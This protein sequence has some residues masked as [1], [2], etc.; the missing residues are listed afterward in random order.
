MNQAEFII[1]RALCE[2]PGTTTQRIIAEETGFSL[3]KVNKT[4]G[5]LQ[6]KS[7][8]SV[9]Y[10]VT[11]AGFQ[12]MEPY[13]VK[14]A[15]ILA[16]G[17][18]TRFAPISYEIPKGLMVVKGAVMIERQIQQL[19][20]AG[21][22]EIV[23]VV[24]CMLEKFFY[25][26]Q[27]YNAKLVVNN[28]F[29][30]KNTHS[31]LFA[32]RDYLSN[33]YICCSD[34]YYPQNMFHAYEYRAYYCAVYLPGV[35][36]GERGLLF[37]RDGLIYHTDRPSKDQWVMQGH[38]YFDEAFSSKFRPVLEQCFGK[39]GVENMYWE[40]IWAEHTQDILLWVKQCSSEQLLEFDRLEDLIEFDP[41][42]LR[43]NQIKLFENICRTLDCSVEDIT[44]ISPI[45]QGLNNRSF[46]FRCNGHFY[47][48]RHPGEATEREIDRKKEA[49][50]LYAA[51][52]LGID[53]T[54]IYIDEK[55][56]WKISKFIEITEP[57]DF[58][59]PRHSKMLAAG[60]KTLHNS[61]ISI[62][63]RF[64]YQQRAEAIIELEK[65]ADPLSYRKVQQEQVAMQP[66]FQFLEQNPWQVSLCHNDLYEP[67]LLVSHD[68]LSMID[69]EYGGDS[70]IG[71]DICKLFA[72]ADVPFEQIN[73]WVY[74]YFGRDISAEE[75]SHLVA[76]AAV[77]YY[78]WYVW[79]IHT[80]RMNE[81]ITGFLIKWYDRMVRF[82]MAAEKNF[83]A[84]Q[85]F[86]R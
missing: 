81:A 35:A 28:E 77:V 56:G 18:S 29:S 84:L 20:H 45:E 83:K 23:V 51:K 82:R 62:G 37:D 75:E 10:Q 17:M 7:L 57:F 40:G 46:R 31:S 22:Q 74:P 14:N 66:I 21:V 48:Y 55:E 4:I 65:L 32:A 3:G 33:T 2:H 15:V 54:L 42:C 36:Y 19:L 8:L 9:D 26:R 41:D 58:A 13:K 67:N 30:T 79:G 85:S 72:A 68:D 70:D 50:A 80:Q 44:E 27:K 16:A 59:N 78:Y 64:D 52:A 39:P 34:I 43:N 61:G 69:W 47:V 49:A 24:G 6:Q 63:K 5:V 1:L 71:F 76:C 60:L 73:Q 12:A 11:R 86:L 53:K 38:A 25:L